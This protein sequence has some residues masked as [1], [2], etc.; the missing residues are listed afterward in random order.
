VSEG[1]PLRPAEALEHV[2]SLLSRRSADDRKVTAFRRAADVIAS[3]GP[4]A[5]ERL[6]RSG[7]LRDLPGIGASTEQVVV[8]ALEGRVPSYLAEIQDELGPLDGVGRWRSFLRGDCHG[9][10][11]WSDG[12]SSIQVMA[13]AASA[14]GHE[15]WTLTDH[16]ARLTV[17]HGLDADRL[18][19]QLG[20]VEAL[21]AEIGAVEGGFRVLTGIEV[22]ILEDGNL[23]MDDELL[24]RL[25]VV[26]ASA[27][28]AL[29]LP[30]PEMTER[31]LRALRS[32]HVDILG[33]CTGRMVVGRGRPPSTFD[34]DAVFATCVE[35][36]K[37]LEVNCRPERLDPPDE[38]LAKHAAMGGLVAVDTDAHSP[39]Q[40]EWHHYGLSK[41]AST[42]V[43]EEKVVNAWPLAQL[44]EWTAGHA[45]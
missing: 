3:A 39:G 41:M 31:L 2:A 30:A 38:L 28:S 40:L 17:A 45:A 21:N 29:R 4:D 14:V 36:G 26:V 18:G 7:H 32:P 44:L 20:V 13:R 23:D 5:V 1:G 12:S 24:G 16:S 9:H 25:D 35:L 10:S 6:A 8:E 27:H 42:G 11:E 19:S 22:D 43:G 33:H 15:Y 34:A 37:A